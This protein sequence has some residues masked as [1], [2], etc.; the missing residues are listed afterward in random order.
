MPILLSIF[1]FFYFAIVGVYIIFIPKVLAMTG[2]SA[3]DIG[4]IFAASPLVR[5]I[6]PFAF[7]KGLKINRMMFNIS[8]VILLVSAVSFYFSLD[9]FY[10]LLLSNIGM[11]IGMSV[12]LPYIEVISLSIMGKEKYGKIR[13]FGSV[14]FV[15]VALVLV[16]YLTSANIALLYL[17][18][19]TIMTSIFAFIIVSYSHARKKKEDENH[20]NDIS[21]LRDW[22]LWLGL[23]LMQVSFGSF[24]NFF[25]IYETDFGVSLDV[26]IYLWTFGVFMEIIMLFFQ[27]RLL[28][29]NLL[30]IL[31]ITTFASAV[32]WFLVYLYPENIPILYFT[33]SLHALSFALFHS[34]AISYLYH[35]YKHRA[36]AQQFFSGITYGMG[37]FTGALIAG[38]VYE[39]Y[40]R[41]LFLSSTLFAFLSFIF[42]VLQSKS[43]VVNNKASS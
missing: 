35:T 14:G 21:L 42:L 23:T 37:G 20:V 33:Q 32:R 7:M 5:F 2:Y 15:L 11:G 13:L 25:T 30:L 38:Y 19:A 8:L 6:L 22:K 9:N 28:K 16:K 1:Y 12:I 39:W 34:A 4:I 31:Q 26:T 17:L 29:N 3:S 40:P 36:L 43:L 27:G 41:E 18:S 24:Y 10:I